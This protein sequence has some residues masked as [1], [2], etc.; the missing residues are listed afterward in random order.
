MAYHEWGD[1]WS[2]WQELDAAVSYIYKEARKARI[3]GQIKEKYG[4]VR[5]YAKFHYMVNDLVWPGHMFV[6]WKQPSFWPRGTKWF[7]YLFGG[8]LKWAD[9]KLYSNLENNPIR[10]YI[11]KRQLVKYKEIYKTAVLLFPNVKE[12]IMAGCEQSHLF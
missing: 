9:Y 12:E 7:C 1:D 10:S 8:L 5:W 11:V 2:H 3:G 6:R 4:T